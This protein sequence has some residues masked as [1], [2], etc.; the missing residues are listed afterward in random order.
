MNRLKCVIKI[1]KHEGPRVFLLVSFLPHL[2]QLQILNIGLYKKYFISL[3]INRNRFLLEDVFKNIFGPRVG[4][5]LLY[6]TRLL[7]KLEI[8]NK[9]QHL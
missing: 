1:H 5:V 7:W 3:I 8:K 9:A 6:G 2:L 4:M